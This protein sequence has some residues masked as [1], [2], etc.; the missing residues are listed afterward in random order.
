MAH[1]S[2][3]Q[4]ALASQL[5]PQPE[6]SL[7][8]QPSRPSSSRTKTSRKN[9]TIDAGDMEVDGGQ[10][11]SDDDEDVLI[12]ST[13]GGSASA[14]TST[15]PGAASSSGFAALP[16]N[17]GSGALKN[18][19]RRVPIPPHRFSPLKRDWVQIYTPLVE[20][21][22]LQVRMNQKRR[23]VEMRVSRLV[24]RVWCGYKVFLELPRM[25]SG[26]GGSRWSMVHLFSYPI[27]MVEG[28]G[29]M[30]NE[31]RVKLV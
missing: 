16:A 26:C 10:S 11:G 1:K 27:L 3:R 4:K 21:L 29:L 9:V 25:G 2:H 24:Q 19:F 22:G 15:N 14:S 13:A 12:A 20:N 18:E 28:G 23:C 6:I 30:V 5:E 8:T 7:V 31:G 17:A